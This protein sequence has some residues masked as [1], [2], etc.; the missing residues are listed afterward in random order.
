MTQ[1]KNGLG[2]INIFFSVEQLKMAKI[3]QNVFT[4]LRIQENANQD[5]TDILSHPSQNGHDQQKDN[6]P[7]QV[8]EKRGAF[9]H[10]CWEHILLQPL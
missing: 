3:P 8:L 6:K 9:I 7:E 2:D 10:G 5:N 4:I 1:F